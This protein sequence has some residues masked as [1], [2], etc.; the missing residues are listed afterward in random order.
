LIDKTA[1]KARDAETSAPPTFQAEHGCLTL[2]LVARCLFEG[3]RRLR[4]FCVVGYSGRRIEIRE[5]E[6]PP[7]KSLFTRPSMCDQVFS[8]LFFPKTKIRDSFNAAPLRSR[9]RRRLTAAQAKAGGGFYPWNRGNLLKRP[10]SN[11]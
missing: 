6:R 11:E 10:N 7:D 2:T 8:F 9:R 4:V 1:L 5:G 3:F